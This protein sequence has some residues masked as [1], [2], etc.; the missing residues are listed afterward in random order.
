MTKQRR[1]YIFTGV[2]I[3]IILA[4]SYWG[5]NYLKNKDL[6]NKQRA[7]YILYER[8]EGLNVSSAVTM[9]GFQIGQ[10][11]DIKMLTKQN[12][13][14]LVS[15]ITDN[16]Y[17]IPDSSIAR[18][19]SMDLMGTKGIEIVLSNSN[20]YHE[21]DDTLIGETEQSLKEQVSMQMM[22]IRN[23]AEDLMKE[24]QTAIEVVGYIFNEETQRNLKN[25]FSSIK[26]T[27]S[28]IETSSQNL[29]S[30]MTEEKS[31][32][33]SIL[34]NIDNITSTI[35]NNNEAISNA[36]KNISDLSDSL[37]A[38]QLTQTLNQANKAINNVAVITDKI[39][40]GKG[41]LGLLVNN[42]SLYYEL[43]SASANL[44]RLVQ[45]MRIN[46]KRYI[47]LRLFDLRRDIMVVDESSLNKRDKKRLE[48]KRERSQK[49]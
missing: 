4:T 38:A 1:K 32:I 24:M 35:S 11:D 28:Y 30:L 5:F 39:N 16:K 49:Q 9:N 20:T 40:Q 29:D 37:K 31:R 21:D 26:R 45:D 7:Y 42:D 12:N 41:S 36:I 3:V 18:I 8:V 27:V 34:N 10:V 14:L 23:Q 6:F 33:T 22:P 15:I 17:A 46:P 25:S 2:L 13:Q 47:D 43:E 19:Y 44:N 48:K